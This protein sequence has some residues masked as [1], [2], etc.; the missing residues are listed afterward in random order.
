MRVAVVGGG[1]AGLVAAADLVAAGADVTLFEPAA[2]GGQIKTRREAGFVV[3]EGAEGWVASDPDLRALCSALDLGDQIVSQLE[4]RSLLYRNGT[5]SD[6]KPGNA[7]GLLGIQAK[8]GDL[9]KGIVSLR[10]GTGSLVDALE[11]QLEKRSRPVRKRAVSLAKDAAALRVTDESGTAFGVDAA[12]VAIPARQAASLLKSPDG[13]DA[14][15]K[16]EHASNVSVSLAWHRGNVS[17]PLDASGLVIDPATEAEGL[18]AC[19]FSSS[20]LPHRA[21]TDAVLLRAFFRPREG[22]IDEPDQAWRE[23]ATRLLA[24]MLGISGAPTHSWVSR[25]MA[26]LPQY[27]AGHAAMVEKAGAAFREIGRVALAGAVY[28]P[29]GIPGAVRS[30]HTA[31]REILGH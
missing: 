20:K 14:L 9:G 13:G 26:L 11:R 15:T 19:A 7:A 29:G 5:L 3:E 18:R 2:L 25:W 12:V 1:L 4:L 17:H 16:I 22:T 10:D 28:S 8:D 31:A 21:P 23:R 27:A 6:L 24:P 30:G